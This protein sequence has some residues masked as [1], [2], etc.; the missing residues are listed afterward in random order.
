[1][2]WIS[3]TAKAP[4]DL[5]MIGDGRAIYTHRTATAGDEMLRGDEPPHRLSRFVERA[6]A[7]EQHSLRAVA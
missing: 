3:R 2:A 7:K 6:R 1:M 5:E 4:G